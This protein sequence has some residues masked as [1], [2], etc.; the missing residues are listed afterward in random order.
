M[1]PTDF[2]SG[3]F[4]GLTDSDCSVYNMTVDDTGHVRCCNVI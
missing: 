2:P 4:F 3:P 1:D